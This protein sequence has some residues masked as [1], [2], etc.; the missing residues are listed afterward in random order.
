MS[1]ATINTRMDSVERHLSEMVSKIDTHV[2]PTS[3]EQAVRRVDAA[4]SGSVVEMSFDEWVAG[5]AESVLQARALEVCE[6]VATWMPAMDFADKRAA[7]SI[8]AL[9][10]VCGW[11]KRK[12]NSKVK[13]SEGSALT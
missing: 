10:D 3:G 7:N 13:P 6:A 12:P 9:R 8:R 4:S 2:E 5:S 11:K 1:V